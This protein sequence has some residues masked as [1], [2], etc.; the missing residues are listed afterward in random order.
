[1]NVYNLM[2]WYS[3]MELCVKGVFHII[4]THPIIL[5]EMY[6]FIKKYCLSIS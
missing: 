4:G 1:M 3:S 5:F 6:T 2:A